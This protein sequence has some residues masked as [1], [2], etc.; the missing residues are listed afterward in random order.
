MALPGDFEFAVRYIKGEEKLCVLDRNPWLAK[1]LSCTDFI[2]M[3]E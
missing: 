3:S 2:R 1:M